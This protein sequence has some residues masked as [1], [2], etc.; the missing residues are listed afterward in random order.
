[1][2]EEHFIFAAQQINPGLKVV[3]SAVQTTTF[4]Q[5]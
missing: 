4:Q 5:Q 2:D 1:M 3:E